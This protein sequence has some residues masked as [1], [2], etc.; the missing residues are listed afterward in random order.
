M[1]SRVL[2]VHNAK[3][4]KYHYSHAM[5]CAQAIERSIKTFA[6]VQFSVMNK[7]ESDAA[8][9]GGPGPWPFKL[10]N[11]TIPTCSNAYMI[12]SQGKNYKQMC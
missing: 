7:M 9:V 6:I 11:P 3:L 4:C 5:P 2:F 10:F 1:R 8:E 12:Y